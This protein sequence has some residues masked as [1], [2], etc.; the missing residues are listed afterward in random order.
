MNDPDKSFENLS[1]IYNDFSE[2]C[3]LAGNVSEADTRVKVIDRI[4]KECLFWPESCIRREGSADRGYYDYIIENNNRKLLVIE[5][6]KK[7]TPFTLPKKVIDKRKYKID[8]CIKTSKFIQEAI[9]QVQRYCSDIGC[10][11]AIASNGYA[12]II[13]RAIREDIPWKNGDCIIYG[14]AGN[15]KKNF[16]DFWNLLSHDNVINGSLDKAFSTEIHKPINYYRPNKYL[17]NPDAPMLRNSYHNQLNPFVENI[18]RDI[19][20]KEQIDILKKCYVW[21]KSLN[22]IDTDLNLIIKDSIPQFIEKEGGVDT[23]PSYKS[24]NG[25]LGQQISK[26]LNK[27]YGSLFLLLGGIGSGKT[28]YI[29]R[30]LNYIGKDFLDKFAVCFY[31]DF[32]APPSSSDEAE[33]FLY[34]SILTQ[35]RTN[36]G[37]LNIE[38]H[39]SLCDIYADKIKLLKET[40]PLNFNFETNEFHNKLSNKLEE[41]TKYN[42]DYV[43]R[44]I[45]QTR[46]YDKTC[47]LFV[48]N[49]D[50]LS[51]EYQSKIFLISQKAA[52]DLQSVV[53]IALREESYYAAS[54]RHTFTAYNN[55][56]FHIAS[57]AFSYL[58]SIRLKYCRELLTLSETE[59]QFILKS[60]IFFDKTKI[61]NFLNII[62]RSIFRQNRNINRFIEAIS[63]GN[64][65]EALD[66][67]STFLYSGTTNVDKMLKIYDRDGKYFVA[68]HEFAKSIILGD[69]KFFKDSV[70]KIINLFEIS[71]RKNSSHFTSIRLLSLLLSY[72]NISNSEGRGFIS[73]NEIIDTF[74]DI[75]DN[76]MDIKFT[77]NRLLSKQLIQLDTRS[78]QTIEKSNF[79]RITSAGYYYYKYLIRS[80]TYLD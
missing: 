27:N 17:Y 74:I 7:G 8:G 22:I 6:K 72:H 71:Q 63:F 59:I 21:G 76:E 48:D 3:S 52:R 78:L 15:I 23:T 68:F 73:I 5:A 51:P 4:L 38:S 43:S 62:E 10:R 49:V 57:P 33:I 79:V 54:I 66:M 24:D 35:F 47:V 28:T 50:Q 32:L 80:F 30:Y 12:W 34:N 45:R 29:N 26:S 19:S 44:L 31:V 70:S 16:I 65:R 64:M 18:F 46:K 75:F 53:V 11:Y 2:F 69:R 40:Y 77:M 37:H 1:I 25:N 36:Y 42:I 56:K 39:D 55:R 20:S 9:E 58:I 61:S 41:W 67:F 14:S 13:F 60:G